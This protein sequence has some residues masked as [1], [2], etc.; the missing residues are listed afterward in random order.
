LEFYEEWYFF[1]KINTYKIKIDFVL[2][3]NLEEVV[4]KW[5]KI[6]T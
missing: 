3:K 6:K 5:V 4:I 1:I 2:Y